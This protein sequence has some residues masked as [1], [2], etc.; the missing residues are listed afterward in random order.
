MKIVLARCKACKHEQEDFIARLGE[1]ELEPC[2]ECGGETEIVTGEIHQ[3]SS[4]KFA[5]NPG[6]GPW[7]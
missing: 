6:S 7:G 1:P 3:V 4:Q 2:S 5:K